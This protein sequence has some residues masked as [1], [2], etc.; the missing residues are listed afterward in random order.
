MAVAREVRIPLLVKGDT[1]DWMHLSGK[2]CVSDGPHMTWR[3]RG[4]PARCCAGNGDCLLDR[5][6]NVGPQVA[7]GGSL[8]GRVGCGGELGCVLLGAQGG[9]E[10]R[11]ALPRFIRDRVRKGL[12]AVLRDGTSVT[13]RGAPS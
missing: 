13:S 1:S 6:R 9:S 11:E 4:L 8:G 12:E 7:D 2:V 10:D 5:L 3:R